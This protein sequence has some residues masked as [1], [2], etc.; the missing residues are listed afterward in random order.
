[1]NATPEHYLTE[2][3]TFFA[4]G[5]VCRDCS[6]LLVHFSIRLAALGRA[7]EVLAVI[8]QSPEAELFTALSE[9]LR[10]YLGW[11]AES[12][13]GRAG[14]IAAQIQ[15]AVAEFAFDRE[16]VTEPAAETE[17]GIDYGFVRAAMP[18]A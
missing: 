10:L 9:G 8:E 15:E 17:A 12:P 6:N 7:A 11:P 2:L 1:M 4:D 3:E 5:Q 13:S 18:A 14:E 16:A